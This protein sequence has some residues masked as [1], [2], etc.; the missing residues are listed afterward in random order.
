MISRGLMLLAS[1]F[2]ARM[3]GKIGYGELGMI[4]STVGMFGAFAGFGLGITATKYVAEFRTKDPA[5]AGRVIATA[6]VFAVITGAAMSAALLVFAPWLAEHGINAPHLAGTLRI[7][8]VLL[9][10]T[11]MNGS[12]TGA[13]A[14]FEAF[15]TI[16]Q[17]NLCVGLASFPLIAGGAYLGGLDGAVWGLA[18]SAGIHWALNRVALFHLGSRHGVP[19]AMRGW[20]SEM[21]VL[22]QFSLPAV[23][24]NLT[25]GPALWIC[26]AML[27]H[28]PNGY[29]E[30]ALFNA[31]NQWFT[32]AL[33]I[34]LLMGNVLLA[35]MS[36]HIGNGKLPAAKRTFTLAIGMNIAVAVPII[37]VVIALAPT[38]MS[39][40]GESFNQGTGV[41]ALVMISAGFVA[42]QT[43][44][45][46]VMT[47][48]GMMWTRVVICVLWALT[49][50]I[51]TKALL[52][53]GALGLAC[54][55]LAAYA[56]K[57][58]LYVMAA[59]RTLK[60][61]D[62]AVS[63]TPSESAAGVSVLC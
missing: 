30:L 22:W 57:A 58:I 26:A 34:P 21:P 36:D 51:V 10:L 5:R 47:A 61:A 62:V 32:A 42:L 38:I 15:R 9:F 27:A 39:L 46:A 17:V 7:G 24:A 50:V 45:E 33:F 56:L 31:A 48:S 63:C 55:I 8:A 20:T 14:G 25:W 3:L 13:M 4:Q 1:I 23:L 28:R 16:A 12:Q 52:A 59:S 40:Y 11:A 49:V 44:A 41:L 37:A 60:Q 54:A 53:Y 18:G 35:S 6:S 19:M 43:P 2:V 29:G